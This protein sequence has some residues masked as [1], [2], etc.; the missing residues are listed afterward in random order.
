M[1][2]GN[3]PNS[4]ITDNVEF[5]DACKHS[6]WE[7]NN[8]ALCTAWDDWKRGDR[9]VLSTELEEFLEI[10]SDLIVKARKERKNKLI[11]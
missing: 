1:R 3:D 7:R 10:K 4:N 5:I 6:S 2:K 8:Q 9:T 11:S